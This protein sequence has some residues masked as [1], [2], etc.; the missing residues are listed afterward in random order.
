MKTVIVILILVAFSINVS[1]QIST[2]KLNKDDKELSLYNSKSK[3]EKPNDFSFNTNLYLWALSLDGSTALPLSNDILP[4]TPVVD[5]KLS[6]ADAVKHL[7]MAA[8]LAGKFSYK[9]WGFLYDINYAKLVYDGTVPVSSGYVSATL[10]AK[11]FTGDFSI[12]YNF[13]IANKNITFESYAGTRIS[14]L[15]NTLDLFASNLLPNTIISAKTWVDPVIG[16]DAKFS[17]SKH[18]FS[19]IKGD[20]GGFGISSHFTGMILGVAG[21]KF[22]DNWNST[23]GFKYLYMN[24]DKDNYLWKMNQYGLLLSVGY[25]FN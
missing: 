2:N 21:Y 11:Q 10:T 12:G 14:Y 18:W 17:F 16:A 9:N 6:F 5:I 8:M 24:Y 13:P 1:A 7:K 19:Y 4:Q 23:L 3:T 20:I 22:S 25:M 15:D